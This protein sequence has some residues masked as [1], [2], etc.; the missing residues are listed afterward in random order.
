M[1]LRNYENRMQ[2]I[3]L[4]GRELVGFTELWSWLGLDS[5]DKK[6]TEKKNEIKKCIDLGERYEGH[7]ITLTPPPKRRKR[8]RPKVHTRGD[9][10]L[11]GNITHGLG[12]YR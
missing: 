9:L 8:Y 6:L 4:D 2:R 12:L 3:W 7:V 1:G 11:I 5:G 10:L